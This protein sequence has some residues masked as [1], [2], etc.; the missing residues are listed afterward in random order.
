[1]KSAPGD[2]ISFQIEK[3]ENEIG[4]VEENVTEDFFNKLEEN[5]GEELD[6]LAE[7]YANP[8]K[9]ESGE[10]FEELN[11]LSLTSQDLQNFVN[12]S[13]DLSNDME[14]ISE[15][16]VIVLDKPTG[17][18]KKVF[19]KEKEQIEKYLTQIFYI[20]SVNK[21]FAIENQALLPQ[22]GVSYVGEINKAVQ[23]G[24]TKELSDLKEKAQKTYEEALKV[25]TPEVTKDIHIQTLSIIKY[26]IESVDEKKLV[27][28]NDPMAMALYVGKLQ[29]ALIE[30]ENLKSEIDEIVEEYEIDIFQTELAGG[31]F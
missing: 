29:A 25:E 21:P 16:Q 7:Y 26:L 19:K 6:L 18:E 11:S 13:V 8:E 15:D 30:G 5:K 10:G 17:S 3:T 31:I 24:Q 12:Q 27:D 4:R 9:F 22:L 1:L 20:M 23:L 14:L 2:K 28:Q